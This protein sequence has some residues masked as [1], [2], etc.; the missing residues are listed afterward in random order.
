MNYDEI[1]ADKI[2]NE[3]S[4]AVAKGYYHICRCMLQK[5]Q[6]NMDGQYNL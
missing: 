2:I 1:D 6:Q 3:V 5:E 4:A